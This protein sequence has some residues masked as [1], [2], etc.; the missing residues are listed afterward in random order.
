M[1]AEGGAIQRVFFEEGRLQFDVLGGGEP[2][3]LCGSGLV[4]LLAVLVRWG[5][6]DPTGRFTTSAA[7]DGWSVVDGR[8][9]IVLTKR[10]V[11]VLQ[12]AKAAISAGV[13]ILMSAAGMGQ[14]DLRYL[15][16]SGAFGQCLDVENARQIGLLPNMEAGIVE[17]YGNTA[18]AGCEDA[19]LCE[20]SRNDLERLRACARIINLSHCENFSDLFIDHLFLRPMRM[21]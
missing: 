3:G 1:P 16:V 13:K 20:A 4:D 7:P 17:L 9:D 21:D 18:L 8:A 10:D 19:L 2:T 14:K 15:C 5:R 11:D 12:R 6:L